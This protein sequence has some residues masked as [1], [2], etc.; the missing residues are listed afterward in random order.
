[1]T[2]GT[3]MGWCGG[4]RMAPAWATLSS[5]ATVASATIKVRMIFDLSLPQRQINERGSRSFRGRRWRR[6]LKNR[7]K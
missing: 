3:R 4:F 6:A 2:N 7:R 5:A 1:M